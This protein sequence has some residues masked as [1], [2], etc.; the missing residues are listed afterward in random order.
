[1]KEPQYD[2]LVEHRMLRGTQTLGMMATHSYDHDPKRL[3]FTLARYKFAAKM[4]AGAARVLEI[5]CGDG[6]AT[7][8]LTVAGK[9][10]AV[11]F[12]PAFIRDART[13]DRRDEIDFRV[14]DLVRGGVV[15][16]RSFN[17]AVALDV[18]EHIEGEDEGAFMRNLCGSLMDE[19]AAVIGMPSRESQ[20]HA[21]PQSLAGHVNC[22]T[23]AVF[24]ADLRELFTYVLPFGMND[25]TLHTGFGPMCHYLLAVCC[26]PRR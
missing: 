22:K 24:V 2:V 7:P 21:S 8:L 5:G 6:F 3:A 9:V 4:V 26:G 15:E 23:Q 10:V 20:A 17:A 13:H 12:D 18:L 25:E 1:M 19:S 16:D 11:D 14:H